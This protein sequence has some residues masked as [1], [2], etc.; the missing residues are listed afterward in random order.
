MKK[1]LIMMLMLP[2]VLACPPEDEFSMQVK[3]GLF[4]YLENPQASRYTIYELQ[5]LV[6]IY[7]T[8][9]VNIADCDTIIGTNTG[10]AAT[11]LLKKSESIGFGVIP[12]CSDGTMYGEC[13]E[14]KP[15]YCYSGILKNMCSGPD[16]TYGTK[17][18]CGCENSYNLCE[19]DGSCSVGSVSCS[20]DSHCGESTL[21][22]EPYCLEE[23][24]ASDYL[25]F[26]CIEPGTANS[27]CTM[28]NT[29]KIL[30]NCTSTCYA[31]TCI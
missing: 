25:Q 15:K 16:E 20:D 29:V 31:G 10:F 3:K 18:D 14:K 23:N 19:D 17:D 5:D 2:L 26:R 12:K 9:D 8:I 7:L 28:E 6:T 11:Q 30:E 27:H 21:T 1:L 13:S 4:N 24:V 22:G